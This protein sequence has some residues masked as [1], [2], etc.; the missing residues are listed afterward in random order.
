MRKNTGTR[1]AWAALAASGVAAILLTLPTPGVR[2]SGAR[3]T[4]GEGAGADSRSTP[5]CCDPPSVGGDSRLATGC[6][7]PSRPNF[8]FILTDDMDAAALRHMPRTRR[9][10]GGCGATFNNMF[11]T[12]PI[13]CPSSVS[14]LTGQY[15]HNNGILHNVPP[16]GGFQK[17]VDIGGD[18]STLATWLHDGGYLTGRVGKYLVGYPTG[19]T[20]VPPGWDDWHSTYEGSTTYFN[21]ALNENGAVVPYGAAEDDYI[22]DVLSRK[23][24][25]FLA[26]AEANDDQPF[27]LVFAPTAP[28]AGAAQNGPPTPAPRH[29]GSFAGV[30]APRPPSF[31]EADVSDK[32]P[33]IRNLP[34]LTAAQVAAIDQEYQARLESL[35]AVDEAVE[36]IVDTLDALGELE[37]TYILFTSDNGYHLGQHRLRNGKAQVYEEDIRVPLLVRGPGIP[38]GVSLD[39]FALNIDFAPTIADLARV[40]PGRVM[41]GRSLAPLLVRDTPPPHNWRKDFLVE[42]YRV[43]GQIGEPGFALRTRHELYVEFASGLRELYDIREDPFE[44][45]NLITVADKGYVKRL[46]RRLAELATCSGDG[47][48]DQVRKSR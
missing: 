24:I 5:G 37:D 26:G 11:V 34:L 14:M 12:N 13:C 6:A 19:T 7:V 40:V 39:H 28:H 44:L 21:Y 16:Q 29:R 17:F 20:Y 8:V 32:P 30:T 22:T 3:A 23:A 48:N 41:D 46:S 18:R 36:R 1:S 31:N 45:E 35:Q 43:P 15:S 4:G 10:V 38:E 25:Q 2:G 9:L 27:F 33:A 47:C 42:V